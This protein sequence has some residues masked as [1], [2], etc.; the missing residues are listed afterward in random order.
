MHCNV[1]ESLLRKLEFL[2][3]MPLCNQRLKILAGPEVAGSTSGLADLRRRELLTEY[4]S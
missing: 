2:R 3:V 1:N 4:A